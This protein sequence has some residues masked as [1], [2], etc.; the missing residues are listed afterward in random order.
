M[1]KLDYCG[2][3]GK[4]FQWITS[5][6]HNRSQQVVIEGTYSSPCKVTSG[7]PQGTVLGP[8]LFLLYIN[9]LI[10]NIQSTVRLFAD[11]CLIYQPINSPNDHQLLQ[12]DLNTLNTWAK[13]WQMKFNIDKCCI[14][15]FSK[16]HH[17]TKFPY[18]MS[19]KA[20]KVVEQNSY[21][22]IIIDYH[23]SWVPQINHVCNK[24]TR[25]IVFLQRNL[26]NYSC[27]LKELS[28][29]QFILP[30]LKYAAAIWDP[31]H[32][33]DINKIEMIQHRTA[34]FVLNRP[35]RRNMRDS[36]TEMLT[37]LEWLP[38]QLRRKCTRL[39][40]EYPQPN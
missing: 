13:T 18:D 2:V 32:L 11:D 27:A 30:V 8:T 16:H 24:A 38:L 12:Q 5:F 31:Y 39:T 35:W 34:R 10:L 26:R 3:R 40:Q 25:L 7:V 15:Q 1:K 20:L 29:K 19:N 28:Y 4:T 33:K 9:D 22:G 6:L 17:K 14:L 37:S 23:L 36:I 21:L